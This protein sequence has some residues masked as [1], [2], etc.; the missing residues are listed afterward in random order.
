MKSNNLQI[1][2]AIARL[3]QRLRHVHIDNLGLRVLSVMLAL[4]LFAVARQPVSDVRISSVP[5]EFRGLTQGVEISGSIDQTVSLRMRGPRDV[6]RGL[7]PSQLS[8]VAN[9]S[10]KEPGERVIQ[11]RPED[12]SRPDNVQVIQI[13]PPSIKLLLEPTVSKNVKIEPQF[14]GLGQGMEVYKVDPEPP[15]VEIEGPLSQ[16][17]KVNFVLTETVNLTQRKGDF[18]VPVD[19]ET[20]H[21]SLRVKVPSP[22]N[23]SVEIGELRTTRRFNK[24]PIIWVDQTPGVRLLEKTVNVELYGPHSAVE[25]LQLNDLRVELKSGLFS[26]DSDL[27]RPEVRLPAWANGR[28]KVN[29]I[30]P[31]E[32]RLKRQ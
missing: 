7:N 26:P 11:L 15:E 24:V 17:S 21:N 28:I 4:A 5:L 14:F 31:S 27:I 1:R 3:F 10:N 16:V 6:M 20:P 13:D 12:V 9:L 25:S 32:V 8:V 22:I 2:L 18:R 23:L 19:I 29:N 30:I